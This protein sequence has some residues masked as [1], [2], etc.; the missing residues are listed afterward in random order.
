MKVTSYEQLALSWQPDAKEQKHF[1]WLLFGA[2][3]LATLLAV[4]ISFIQVPDE[5]RQKVKVPERVAKFIS[6]KPKPVQP[7]PKAE[8]KPPPKPVEP[9]KP[10]VAKKREEVQKPL[11]EQQKKA[12]DKA[13]NT[14][15]LALASEFSDLIDSSAVDAA[16]SSTVKTGAGGKDKASGPD[17]AALLAS[18][19]AKAGAGRAAGSRQVLALETGG[20]SAADLVA[21]NGQL[22]AQENARA[23]AEAQQTQDGERRGDH[24]RSEEDISVVFDQNKAR[25]QSIYNRERRRNPGLQGKIVFEVTVEPSGQVSAVKVLSSEL[26]DAGLERR[27]A[28]RIKTFNF[29]A[30]AVEPVT[31]TFPIEF[32]PS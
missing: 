5:P 8:P 6:Q 26:N 15:L 20:L 2:L 18:S 23:L 12:R 28:A 29:G 30:R 25:L 32:L 1:L 10:K 24:L 16:V 19:T 9:P 13:A 31:V 3:L 27:L 7:P 11:T 17:V 4:L 22:L 14:G 21:A